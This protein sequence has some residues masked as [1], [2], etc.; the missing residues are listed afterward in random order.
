MAA[1]AFGDTGQAE[2][3]MSHCPEEHVGS[4]WEAHRQRYAG[5]RSRLS[6]RRRQLTVGRRLETPG[7]GS[8]ADESAYNAQ[9]KRSRIPVLGRVLRINDASLEPRDERL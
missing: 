7:T 8:G 6:A 2:P 3:G 5:G 9:A 4:A 1:A